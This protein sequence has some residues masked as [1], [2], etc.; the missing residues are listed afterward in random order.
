MVFFGGTVIYTAQLQKTSTETFEEMAQLVDCAPLNKYVASHGIRTALGREEIRMK[1]GGRMKFLARTR[2]GGNGQ[3]GSLLI[4]DEA[5]YLDQQSQGSFLAAISACRTLRGPQTI[6]NGN[7]PEDGDYALVFERIRDDALSGR[8]KHTAWSEWSAGYGP[9]P[10]NVS[11]P[12]VWERTNPAFGV[13]IGR[14]TIE[15]EYE[16]ESTEQFAHQRCGWFKQRGSGVKLISGETWTDQ[17]AEAPDTWH[18]LAY[19]VK[20]TPDGMYV[21]LSVAL[22]KHDGTYHVEFIEQRSML[23]GIGWLVN[24]VVS[25]NGKFEA[26]AVDGKATVDDFGRQLKDGGVPSSAI[27]KMS[28]A[29][30]I[31]SNQMFMNAL[32]DGVLTHP[33]DDALNTAALDATR[34]KI[35]NDGGFGFSGENCCRIE[36]CAV[37]LWAVK[38]TKRDMSRKAVVW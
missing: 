7:A 27:M 24:W 4:F 28:T 3:H 10:P 33:D 11:S 29:D 30:V 19:G 13:L 26:I 6:Y 25:R 2:N 8:T 23:D 20:F 34:R 15:A 22:L 12:D 18:K 31:T 5:Q 36:S 9:M 17:T 35:G 32:N 38:T 1:N 37:A 21:S 14:D 16:S